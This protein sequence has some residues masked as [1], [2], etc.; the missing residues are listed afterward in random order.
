MEGKD[1]DWNLEHLLLGVG[2]LMKSNQVDAIVALDDYD[3]EK[4]PIL[5]RTCELM[6]WDKLRDATSGIN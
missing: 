4:Q 2:N 1:I 3:V 5:E 6:V